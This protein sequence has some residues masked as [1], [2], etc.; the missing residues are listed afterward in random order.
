MPHL[1]NLLPWRDIR[2]QRHRRRFYVLVLGGI[3]ISVLMVS[4]SL[5]WLSQQRGIQQQRVDRLLGFKQTAKQIQTESRDAQARRVKLSRRTAQIHQLFLERQPPFAL[6]N[7]VAE[8]FQAGV[9]ADRLI[10]DDGSVTL[11]G[12][13]ENAK[14][15]MSILAHI[16]QYPGAHDV[17]LHSIQSGERRFD[18]AMERFSLRSGWM[19]WKRNHMIDWDELRTEPMAEWPLG[20]QIG[21]TGCAC[22]LL[23]VL[24]YFCWISPERDRLASL[25]QQEEQLLIWLRQWP[26]THL[27]TPAEL[28]YPARPEVNT[29]PADPLPHSREL[30]ALL[31]RM[32]Q[33][34]K[35]YNV[36]VHRI[37]RGQTEQSGPVPYVVLKMELSGR[38]GDIARFTHEVTQATVLLVFRQM[39]WQ[40]DSQNSSTLRFQA[41]A[42]LYVAAETDAE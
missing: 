27:N 37:D 16:E 38:Y 36:N 10:Y 32:Y 24:G 9:Y 19:R 13:C 23:Y 8:W 41:L 11:S 20:A 34:G 39:E 2:R 22:F 31:V 26:K 5:E 40:R 1:I 4:V 28:S 15:L 6:M 35:E 12:V 21:L 30:P 42:H 25:R 29:L 14:T 3:L 18:T 7:R 33:L 17:Q